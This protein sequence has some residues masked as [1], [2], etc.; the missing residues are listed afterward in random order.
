[1]EKEQTTEIQ[2]S[3]NTVE[4]LDNIQGQLS[5]FSREPFRKEL[6]RFLSNSR[7]VAPLTF[8]KTSRGAS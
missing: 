7:G 3:M 5:G 8:D 1:M 4:V 6:S 2:R